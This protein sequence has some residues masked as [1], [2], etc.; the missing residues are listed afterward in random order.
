MLGIPG[1]ADLLNVLSARTFVNWYNAHPHASPASGTAPLFDLSKVDR[2]SIVGQGNVA[3]D[4]ARVLLTDVDTLAKTDMAEHALAELARSRVK[5][6]E[7]VGRRGP[8]QIACTTK[9]V[10][11]MMNLPG[12]SFKQ[13]RRLFDAAT[14]MMEQPGKSEAMPDARMKRRLLQLMQKGSKVGPDAAAKEWSFEFFRSPVAFLGDIQRDASSTSSTLEKLTA[15]STVKAV[16]WQETELVSSD[17]LPL[18]SLSV[19]SR[20]PAHRVKT[21]TDLVLKSVGYRSVGVP[22]LPFDER[23]GTVLN[24]NGKVVRED[25]SIVRALFAIESSELMSS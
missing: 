25:G 4:V 12:V 16:E 13:D 18:S 11:E 1:E 23:Q 15:P 7:I 5:H 22:G 20:G 6:V 24:D 21:A 9:E 3:L 14:A 10:R 8:L 17:T 2:V 19:K